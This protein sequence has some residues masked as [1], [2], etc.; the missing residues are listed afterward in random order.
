MRDRLSLCLLLSAALTVAASA[1][2]QPQQPP[3]PPAD[4]RP[5]PPPGAPRHGPPPPGA[6]PPPMPGQMPP[7]G[8]MP[9]RPPPP[10]GAGL[11]PPPPTSPS[12]QNDPQSVSMPPPEPP[13]LSAPPED[14]AQDRPPPES[15]LPPPTQATTVQ[16][17]S[18]PPRIIVVEGPPDPMQAPTGL[19]RP[20]LLWSLLAVVVLSILGWWAARR[21]GR[22]LAEQAERLARQHTRMHV[23]NHQLKAQTERLREQSIQ[24]PLTGVLNRAA[25]ANEFRELSE[26]AEHSGRML[27]LI[28]FDLDHFKTI[29]DRQGHLAGDAALKLVVGIVREHLVSADLFGRFGGDEFLIA[30]ADQP[31]P[32]CRDLAE[33]I[34]QAVETRA[35]AHQPPLPGLSLSMGI[36]QADAETGYDAD[37]LFARADAALYEAKRQGRNRVVIAD[38]VQLADVDASQRHL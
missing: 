18:P 15:D 37:T 13:M 27:N 11:P 2:A 30:C 29:N 1:M 26:R 34:R 12:T 16:T 8:M 35:T 21:R 38:T 5:P 7:P 20:W 33:R 25:F 24:D 14:F 3:M 19:E 23:A 9:N 17:P 22:L 28:V 32:F 4:G 31:L 6:R 10:P 36:A